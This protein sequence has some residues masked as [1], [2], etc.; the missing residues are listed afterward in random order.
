MA[1]AIRTALAGAFSFIIAFA[2]FEAEENAA[3]S[4][5]TT[6]SDAHGGACLATASARVRALSAACN[7]RIDRP[8]RRCWSSGWTSRAQRIAKATRAHWGR[9]SKSWRVGRQAFGIS[10]LTSELPRLHDRRHTLVN[11]RQPGGGGDRG[12]QGDQFLRFGQAVALGDVGGQ[13]IPVALV[14]AL[15]GGPQARQHHQEWL[16]LRRPQQ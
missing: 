12:V 5:I 15:E 7:F 16:P 9:W 14:Q 13:R 4:L 1:A 2:R 6:P 11:Q 3:C 8:R 10:V